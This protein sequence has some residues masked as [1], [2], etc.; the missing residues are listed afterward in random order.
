MAHEEEALGKAYDSRLMRRLLGYLRP[1]RWQVITSLVAI[2]TK[3]G[4]DVLG[5]LL[6]MVAVDKYLAP[7]M[8]RAV[9]EH[10]AVRD[11]VYGWL[12][13]DPLTGIAQITA[14]Y[15]A[16]LLV[17]FGLEFLQTYLMQW[18]GQKAMF[19]LRAELFRHLQRLHIGFFDGTR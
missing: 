6:V 14:T 16:L 19:D 18:T 13:P 8:A 3:A 15:V 4:A 10:A 17:S 7:G 9:T 5:P 1:Y 11:R 12:S 2:V